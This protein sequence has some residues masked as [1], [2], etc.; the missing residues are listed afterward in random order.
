MFL[1]SHLSIR[2]NQLLKRTQNRRP[3]LGDMVVGEMGWWVRWWWVRRGLDT[4]CV[5]ENG[6]D[7][8]TRASHWTFT[9]PRVL[10]NRSEQRDISVSKNSKRE[11][12]R[13]SSQPASQTAGK[14]IPEK[15]EWSLT[16]SAQAPHARSNEKFSIQTG[17]Y[18]LSQNQKR[19]KEKSKNYK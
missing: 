18:P 1:T 9:S 5:T 13:G 14:S 7:L 10:T 17:H 16:N 2:L 19:K 4:T 3:C 12:R 8:F 6:R 11:L 15:Y